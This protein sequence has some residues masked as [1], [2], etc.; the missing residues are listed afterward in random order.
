MKSPFLS[1]IRVARYFLYNTPVRN[2]KLT[3]YVYGKVSGLLV[4]SDS[5]PEIEYLGARLKTIGADTSITTAL[6]NDHYETFTL[7]IL[8]E[9]TQE[10]TRQKSP[11]ALIF[12]DVGANIGIFTITTAIRN[13]AMRI[14]A[15]EPNPQSFALLQENL[16]LNSITNV[17]AINSAVGAEPGTASLD[18]SSP[19]AG[20]HSLFSSGSTRLEVPLVSLDQ[21]FEVRASAPDVIKIDV[22]GYEPLVLKGMATILKQE[23]LQ[24]ILEFN[25]EWLNRGNQNPSAFLA[26]LTQLFDAIYCLDEVLGEARRYQPD[27]AILEKKILSAGFNLL[28]IKGRIPKFLVNSEASH[29]AQ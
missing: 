10:G 9:L 21:Y 26:E 13:P 28:L 22:E 7:G 17:V 18:V 5:F 27:D 25:P 1:L 11:D 3:A 29:K 23:N 20:T 14:H 24:V 8:H 19:C 15:F 12:A 16:S 2:W 6:I 4:R